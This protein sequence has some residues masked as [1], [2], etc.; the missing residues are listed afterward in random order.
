LDWRKAK[1]Y[2]ER[3]AINDPRPGRLERRADAYLKAV[4]ERMAKAK[5][6]RKR[7]RR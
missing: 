3:E 2:R 6:R 4:A 1:A 7:G 5:A